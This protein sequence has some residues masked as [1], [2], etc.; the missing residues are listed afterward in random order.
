MVVRVMDPDQ[1]FSG[2]ELKVTS[3]IR[4][5]FLTPEHAT[6]ARRALDVDR[7]QNASFVER[8]ITV[9]GAELIM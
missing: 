4:V 5:P 8:E 9:E 1:V 3:T 6:I 7:E 2:G